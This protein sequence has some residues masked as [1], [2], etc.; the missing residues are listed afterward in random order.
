MKQS[1]SEN[2]IAYGYTDTLSASILTSNFGVQLID[3]GC[4]RIAARIS[5]CLSGSSKKA[6]M[7]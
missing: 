3:P 5:Q 1:Y 7:A 2:V 6:I 4:E